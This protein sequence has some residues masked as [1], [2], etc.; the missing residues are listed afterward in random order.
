MSKIILFI[1]LINK[2]KN[3]SWTDEELIDL[4]QM[5]YVLIMVNQIP[6]I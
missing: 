4:W 5:K 1:L 3:V 6:K 2:I